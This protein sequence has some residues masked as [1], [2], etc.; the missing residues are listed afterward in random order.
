MNDVAVPWRQS[1]IARDRWK[2]D[3]TADLEFP[4]IIHIQT[5]TRC[6]AACVLCPY[7]DVEKNFPHGFMTMDLFAKITDECAS[8]DRNAEYEILPFLMNEPTLD[9]RLPELIRVVRNR[10]PNAAISVYTNGS[11]RSRDRW[12]EI[13]ECGTDTIVFSVSSADPEEYRTITGGLSFETLSKNIDVVA[14]LSGAG[15]R[16]RPEVIVHIL[17]MGKDTQQLVDLMRYWKDRGIHSR[18]AYVENRGGNLELGSET[19]RK[20]FLAPGKCWRVLSQIHIVEN[21]DVILCCG[22]WRREVVLGNLRSST[23][24]NVWSGGAYRR[25]REGHRQ[26]NLDHLPGICRACNMVT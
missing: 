19:K 17:R 12:A 22:D 10:L 6:N 3:L 18:T 1:V 2:Y 4:R 7:P 9:P 24:R 23:I 8:V 5:Y 25:I 11:L 15:G 16:A 20:N 26:G 13:V 14:E 21:G